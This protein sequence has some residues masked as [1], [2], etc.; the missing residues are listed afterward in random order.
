MHLLYL[1]IKEDSHGLQTVTHHPIFRWPCRDVCHPCVVLGRHILESHPSRD[2]LQLDGNPSFQHP[3]CHLSTPSEGASYRQPKLQTHPP[4]VVIIRTQLE[5]RICKIRTSISRSP[6]PMRP[7][8]SKPSDAFPITK[9]I[10]YWKKSWDD[11]LKWELTDCTLYHAKVRNETRLTQTQKK[12]APHK[13]PYWNTS[14]DRVPARQ[15]LHR[16]GWKFRG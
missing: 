11:R 15:R 1:D 4:M 8:F 10:W 6:Y 12:N 16:L 7:P 5:G 13:M 9:A 2:R 3:A 14:S